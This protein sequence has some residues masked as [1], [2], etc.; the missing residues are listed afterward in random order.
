MICRAL[1]SPVGL[2]LGRMG[3]LVV[4]VSSLCS[5]R[6]LH[7]QFTKAVNVWTSRR[8]AHTDVRDTSDLSARGSC[9]LIKQLAYKLGLR[10]ES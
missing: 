8:W 4:D 1:S 3:E 10:Q 5:S 2:V 6:K 7:R 9:W